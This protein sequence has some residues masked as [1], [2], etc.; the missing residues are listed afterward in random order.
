M[1]GQIVK[2]RFTVSIKKKRSGKYVNAKDD[3]NQSWQRKNSP[4]S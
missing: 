1:K 4:G 3:N 2:P